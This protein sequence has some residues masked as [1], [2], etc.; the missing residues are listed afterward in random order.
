MV[1]EVSMLDGRF[2]SKLD[3]VARSVRNCPNKPFGGIQ[4]VLAGD[5]FQLP[6][7]TRG[8]DKRVFCF[9][10]SRERDRL[11]CVINNYVSF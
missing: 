4:L 6:P 5:F 11:H 10:T 3:G 7:V 2:F 1:D 9:Q 8:K